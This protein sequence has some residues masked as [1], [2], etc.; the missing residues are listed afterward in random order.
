VRA[1][2]RDARVGYVIA[3]PIT[4]P[5]TE[6]DLPT[7]R[8]VTFAVRDRTHWNN[9]WWTDPVLRGAYPEDGLALFGHEMPRF[10]AS[11]LSDMQQPLDFLG[12]NLYKADTFRRG[13]GGAP[14]AVPFR[15]GHPRSG[16]GW[17]PIT[18]DAH[19]YGPRFFHERYGLPL[20]IT[21]SGLSTR[22]QVFLDGKVHDTQ[23]VDYLHRVLLELRRAIAEGVPVRGY[24]AWSLLD[25]F[26]WH[27][28]YSQRFGLVY[29]DYRSQRRIPKDSFHWYRQVIASHGAS[30]AG[31]FELPAAVVTAD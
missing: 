12:I 1:S 19:Y 29:V 21:E 7:A 6:A 22:D 24:M 4:R 28:G 16:V 14:E 13:E 15:P 5:E 25:N 23:R 30:L 8:Q 27:E 11:D 31:E 17:Q 10:P 18:P 26:E 2:A 3:A 20:F 9:A